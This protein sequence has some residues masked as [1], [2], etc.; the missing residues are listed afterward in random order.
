[1]LMRLW[2]LLA[3]AFASAAFAETTYTR[4]ISRIVQGKCQQC[5]RP[6][7]I[8]PFAL[9]TYDDVVTYAEDIKVA[10]TDKKMP[11]WKPA[12]GVNEFRDS[13]A[14]SDEDRALFL[15][16]IDA[17]MPQGEPADA[18]EPTPVSESPWHL[19]E[20]DMILTMPEYT[21]PERATD[22]YR[23][24]VLPTGLTE[25]RFISATQA[26]PGN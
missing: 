6:N 21:P 7:D 23:C 20:P 3:F 2:V 18:P 1:M 26:L 5:H 11:P 15:A 9:T 8:A 25:N 19:G 13:Y 22:T 16:W 14:L 12:P 24:F 4:E 17:G 10:L